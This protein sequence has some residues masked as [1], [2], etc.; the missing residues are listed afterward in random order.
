MERAGNTAKKKPHTVAGIDRALELS[1][2]DSTNGV[3][4][5]PSADS[6][7]GIHFALY[8]LTRFL[9]QPCFSFVS[10]AM[11][12]CHNHSS[13]RDSRPPQPQGTFPTTLR[14]RTLTLAVAATLRVVFPDRAG[15]PRGRLQVIARGRHLLPSIARSASRCVCYLFFCIILRSDLIYR[16]RNF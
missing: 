11:D 4:I 9:V 12:C 5:F 6:C 1:S 13:L 15:H 16:Y 3:K 2:R 10:V 8:P 14:A 7:P